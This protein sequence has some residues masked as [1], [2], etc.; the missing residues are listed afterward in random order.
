MNK[1]LAHQRFSRSN[2]D[3]VA[4]CRSILMCI[5]AFL[6][7]E[8]LFQMFEKTF[9]LSAKWRHIYLRIRSKFE[10]C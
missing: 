5:S 7:E 9:E 6:E 4:I 2:S 10:F 3:I 1:G 8:M